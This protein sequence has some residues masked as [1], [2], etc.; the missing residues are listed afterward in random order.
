M[1]RSM[2]LDEKEVNEYSN[3]IFQQD[4][5]LEKLSYTL[6]NLISLD[7]QEIK[8]VKIN[9][10]KLFDAINLAMKPILE[11]RNIHFVMDI[12]GGHVMGDVDLLYSLFF[13]LIDNAKKSN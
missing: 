5:R 8:F 9:V 4:K 10:N 3:Y 2:A 1:L 6:M 7:K 13:N 11:K 12:E